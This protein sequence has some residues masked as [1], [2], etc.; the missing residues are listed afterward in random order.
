MGP[1]AKTQMVLFGLLALLGC[2]PSRDAP[3]RADIQ[4]GSASTAEATPAKAAPDRSELQSGDL[5]FERSRSRQSAVVAAVTHSHFTHVGVVFVDG[6]RV[7]VLEAVQPVRYTD[8]GAWVRR[9]EDGRFVARRL[10]NADTILTADA[11]QRLRREGERFLGRPYDLRF[12]W[13]DDALYCSEL[14]WKMYDRA[15]GIR[16]GE[17]QHWRDLDLASTAARRLARQRLGH[18]PDP[19]GL[20]ITPARMLASDELVPVTAAT[21]GRVRGP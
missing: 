10:R 13:S 12:E 16:L 11:V 9:S 8:F 18:L 4:V 15:L 20:I 14:V 5:V 7:R 1:T 17:P 3:R 21:A 19:N 6:G 2:H